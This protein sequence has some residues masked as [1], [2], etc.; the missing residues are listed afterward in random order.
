MPLVVLTDA[1]HPD[2]RRSLNYHLGE[3]NVMHAL[4]NDMP[5]TWE[6]VKAFKV[7][8]D[9]LDQ[10]VRYKVENAG[11]TY[12]AYQILEKRFNGEDE[13]YVLRVLNQMREL[14]KGKDESPSSYL[15]R[16]KALSQRL[17]VAGRPLTQS[18]LV[19]YAVAGLPEAYDKVKSTM[20][21]EA[22][23]HGIDALDRLINHYDREMASVAQQRAMFA[24]FAEVHMGQASGSRSG[25]R[26]SQGRGRGGQG[27]SGS[28]R[29]PQ[30][31]V[32]QQVAEWESRGSNRGGQRVCFRC[33]FPGHIARECRAIIDYPP[34]SQHERLHQSGAQPSNWQ[35]PQANQARPPPP[36]HGVQHP[37]AQH[38]YAAV[39]HGNK[40]FIADSGATHHF[41]GE[42][43]Y[44]C[45]YTPNAVHMPLGTAVEGIIGVILGESDIAF[46]DATARFSA[47]EREPNEPKRWRSAGRYPIP[48]EDDSCGLFG[49]NFLPNI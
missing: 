3:L 31:F 30:G 16:V 24:Q 6:D 19:Q 18:E 12:Q 36:P 2:W 22:C 34:A 11:S 49:V 29:G 15:A 43:R 40:P 48:L 8:M 45:N 32:P 26:G 28:G 35:P 4:S 21:M 39:A 20:S 14:K 38:L 9:S 42:L 25:G 23:M 13:N 1:N 7:L 10:E 5:G 27:G 37:M 33:N 41:C 44:M 17:R 46:H 47:T